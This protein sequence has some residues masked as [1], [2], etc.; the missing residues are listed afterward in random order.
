MKLRPSTAALAILLVLSGLGIAQIVFGDLPQYGGEVDFY[1]DA[2]YS[3][4]V[5]GWESICVGPPSHWGTYTDYAI[6]VADYACDGSSTCP[7]GACWSVYY[8]TIYCC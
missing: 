8:E 4:L 6:V 1:S 3:E 5:G 2:T 7:N